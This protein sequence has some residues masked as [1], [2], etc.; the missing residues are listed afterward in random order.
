MT[1]FGQK[2]RQ[3]RKERGILLKDMAFALGVSAAYLSAL[4]HGHRSRP[5]A[6]LVQQISAYFNLAWDDVDELQ[7]LAELS[8]PRIHLDCSG[9]PPETTELANLF[10]EKIRKLDIETVSR[11]LAILKM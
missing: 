1:P 7:R 11:I 10:K 5:K 2:L 8:H 3:L 9:L 6:G 4:E